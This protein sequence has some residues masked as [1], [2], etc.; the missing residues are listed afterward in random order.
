MSLIVS[1]LQGSDDQQFTCQGINIVS[2]A[3]TTVSLTVLG[4]FSKLKSIVCNFSD[5][6]PLSLPS[7]LL[8]SPSILISV[9]ILCTIDLSIRSS[10]N[11]CKICLPL[12]PSS[13]SLSPETTGVQG[14]L[15]TLDCGPTG[16]PQPTVTWLRGGD[17]IQTNARVS[18]SAQGSLIFSPVFSTDASVYTC[19]ATNIVGNSSATTTLIVQ[20]R[21]MRFTVLLLRCHIDLVEALQISL[22]L[23]LSLS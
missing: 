11:E 20:G 19:I 15:L 3:I 9:R 18:V 10:C 4:M 5:P 17:I 6:I 12:V 1:N 21:P 7:Y 13:V 22:T 16:Q 14:R 23:T 8:Y 2:M